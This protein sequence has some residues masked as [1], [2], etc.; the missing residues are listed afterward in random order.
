[1]E[2][3]DD[4]GKYYNLLYQD[5]DYSA[6]VDY[7]ERLINEHSPRAKTILDLGCG[8]GKHDFLSTEKGFSLTGVDLSYQ[9]LEAAENQKGI[10]GLNNKRIKFHSGDIRNIRLEKTFDVVISLFD[11]ISYQTT[12]SDLKNV[13]KTISLH[14]KK[15]GIFIFDC[16][17]GPGVLSHPPTVRVKKL[18]NEKII[19]T[20]IAEPT[21]HFD[22]NIVDVSYHLFV[23]D[24]KTQNVE[25]VR[26]NHT[27]RYLFKPEIEVIFENLNLEIIAFSEFLSESLPRP[28]KWDVCFIGRGKK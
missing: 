8:T 5:K 10:K 16:W 6:E 4:Y 22:K 19:L 23:R 7:I 3:F 1:M 12:N 26:E 2:I 9:M 15:N 25:E 27:M 11:V 24:K 20:R 17:Y 28:D 13:F 14:L 18:E 21:I